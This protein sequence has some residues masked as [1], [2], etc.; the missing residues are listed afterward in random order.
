MAVTFSSKHGASR[1]F[2]ILKIAGDAVV[3]RAPVALTKAVV[4]IG[5]RW[6]VHLP[7]GSKEVSKLHALIVKE[8]DRV[9]I[10][11]LA[12]R[13]RLFVNGHTVRETDLD[14][15]DVV[16]VGPYQLHCASGFT[17]PDPAAAAEDD[18][19]RAPSAALEINGGVAHAP[20]LARAILIGTREE[21]D[22]VLADDDVSPVHAVIF[23]LDGKRFL[24][25]LGSPAGTSVNGAKIHQQELAIGDEIRVGQTRLRYVAAD[26]VPAEADLHH[27]DEGSGLGILSHGDVAGSGLEVLHDPDDDLGASG[28]AH[29]HGESDNLQVDPHAATSSGALDDVLAVRDADH[30]AA[31]SPGEITGDHDLHDTGD[32]DLIEIT[33]E[34]VGES[35][36]ISGIHDLEDE[37]EPQPPPTPARRAT[38]AASSEVSGVIDLHE[39]DFALD[40]KPEDAHIADIDH[41]IE[42]HLAEAP[43]TA[44]D[45]H[46]DDLLTLSADPDHHDHP[47]TPPLTTAQDDE[48]TPGDL[49]FADHETDPD[50]IPIA[51]GDAAIA[52]AA[53]DS[54]P[55]EPEVTARPHPS[56]EDTSDTH[57]TPAPTADALIPLIEGDRPVGVI[58]AALRSAADEAHTPID[59]STPFMG[60]PLLPLAASD[61]A[62]GGLPLPPGHTGYGE[63]DSPADTAAPKPLSPEETIMPESG[64]DS[65]ALAHQGAADHH[66]EP[67]HPLFELVRQQ[68]AHA[69]AP[70]SDSNNPDATPQPPRNGRTEGAYL[71]PDAAP[72][73]TAAPPTEGGDDDLADLLKL[74]GADATHGQGDN[75]DSVGGTG[76]AM[77]RKLDRIVHELSDRVADLASTWKQVKETRPPN[78]SPKKEKPTEP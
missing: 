52:A 56:T 36:E 64:D 44:H 48:I 10:R 8:K 67:A 76:R 16:K 15:G 31:P 50:D 57:A 70:K 46:D 28:V 39:D 59:P 40:A 13:N 22:V 77:V 37:S 45:E 49:E 7:L 61:S 26:D 5:R 74:D 75:G 14:T 42:A 23:E 41:E 24:R 32:D 19:N 55:F 58:D 60:I 35:S 65:A 53:T 63:F 43:A 12:S 47:A 18:A 21:C 1:F 27:D 17:E 11:D 54:L 78:E 62:V 33:R 6:G 30:A 9:Y 4:L 72:D 38:R 66:D 29:L 25:D 69:S 73:P 51:V 34:S 68:D 20:L 71:H 2:P 3:S